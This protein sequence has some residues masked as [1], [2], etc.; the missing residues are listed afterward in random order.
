MAKY[1]KDDSNESSVDTSQFESGLSDENEEAQGKNQYKQSIS[2]EGYDVAFEQHFEEIIDQAE[3]K[4]QGYNR[5][6]MIEQLT[7]EAEN[8]GGWKEYFFKAKS[9]YHQA[10]LSFAR[11][12]GYVNIG[13]FNLGWM[14]PQFLTVV[15][16]LSLVLSGAISPIFEIITILTW[17]AIPVSIY[18]LFDVFDYFANEQITR[19][20]TKILYAL[21]GVIP[22]LGVIPFHLR[23]GKHQKNSMN[24]FVDKNQSVID[25]LAQKYQ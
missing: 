17:V 9:S 2:D 23:S 3:E 6:D 11:N 20:P 24:K 19:K 15:W 1:K 4:T 14:L 18:F 7:T 10:I 8:E 22:V 21:C 25:S 13:G 16:I 5:K 12:D